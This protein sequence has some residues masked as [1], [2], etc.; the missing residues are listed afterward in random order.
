LF[1]GKKRNNQSGIRLAVIGA[2][3][4]GMKHAN[5]ITRLHG[6]QL[7]GICD[8]NPA[9]RSLAGDLGVA[10]YSDYEK[11]IM[12][13]EPDGVIIATPTVL[14]AS[15][16][17]T[18]AQHGVNLFVEKP[19]AADL[20]DA[21]KLVK[22]ARE[23]G[24]NLLVGHHRRFNPIVEKARLT[25]RQR[26]IGKL[27]AISIIWALLKPSDYFQTEWRRQYGG[28]PV[29]INLIHDIDNMRYICGEIE[30]VYAE[31]SSGIRG[32]AVEDSAS[33]TLRFSNGALGGI[34]ASDCVP[35]SWSY[36]ATTGENPYY[37]RT[38]QNCY[39]FFGTK[40]SLSFPDLRLVSYKNPK[41]AGWN[42]PLVTEQIKIK[43]HD[44]LV[45]QIEHFC[46]VIK[47]N[48]KP[49]T[50]GEDALRSLAVAQAILESG[51]LGESVKLS[52]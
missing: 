21:K 45:A 8:V 32:F 44:P 14:H 51:R 20:L 18:C 33:V 7:V 29:L 10:F 38:S 50:S 36:E 22:R 41:Q 24:V 49:R 37:F 1:P 16:G 9:I 35:S 39:F 4:M 40:G 15:I 11:M 52:T 34:I 5:I 47:E 43:S 46:Q 23:C 3:A 27:V 12:T 48:E 13:E 17:I 6:C 2:G 28:G 30:R 25:I 31:T 26:K 19:I 42:F